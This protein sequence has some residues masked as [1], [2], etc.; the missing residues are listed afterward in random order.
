MSEK[1][2]DTLLTGLIPALILPALTLVGFWIV[3]S[4]R[5]FVDFLQHFQQ[6]DMLSKVVS[7]TAIPNLLLFF[8]FIW[9]KRNFSARGVIFATFLLAFVMLILKIV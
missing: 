9:T 6:M 7:L 3:K 5:G 2:F 8:L 1:K 4:D